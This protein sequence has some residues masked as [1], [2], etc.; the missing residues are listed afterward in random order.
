[1][2]IEKIKNIL[3]RIYIH[4]FALAISM[5]TVISPILANGETAGDKLVGIIKDGGDEAVNTL[6]L[7]GAAAAALIS[8]LCGLAA[9]FIIGKAVWATYKT[10]SQESIFSEGLST[11]VI[12]IVLAVLSGLI[13]AKFFI[14]A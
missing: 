5:P 2:K 10:H 14:G 3:K 6:N 13:A 8:S 11:M 9:L 12:L 7:I 1:M 4:T